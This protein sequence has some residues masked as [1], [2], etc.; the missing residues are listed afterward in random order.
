MASRM[1]LRLQQRVALAVPPGR[2]RRRL[3]GCGLR[4]D[5]PVV[6]KLPC[7]GPSFVAGT[8]PLSSTEHGPIGLAMVLLRAYI[9]AKTALGKQHSPVL[10][11]SDLVGGARRTPRRADSVR[12]VRE[13][14]STNVQRTEGAEG[15]RGS[16]VGGLLFVYPVLYRDRE[17]GLHMCSRGRWVML[18]L[19]H[20]N[21]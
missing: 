12:N 19:G 8:L 3:P 1:R 17:R 9:V 13:E 4:S 10:P 15:R 14:R 20:I 2:Q 21:A 6:V 5:V 16:S 11:V 18:A 7:M